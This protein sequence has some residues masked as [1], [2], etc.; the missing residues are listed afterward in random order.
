MTPAVPAT[1]I[2]GILAAW[3]RLKPDPVIVFCRPDDVDWVEAACDALPWPVK[4]ALS[5]I[6]P[7][8]QLYIWKGPEL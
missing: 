3:E 8:G 1:T 7:A 6:M 4:V 5:E 2:A